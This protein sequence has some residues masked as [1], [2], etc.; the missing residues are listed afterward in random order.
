MKK[1]THPLYH[2]DT[3]VSC[4]CGNNFVTGSTQKEIRVEI[5]NNCH[6]FYT[7]K[8]NLI[9]TSGRLE[10]YEEK[11]GKINKAAAA[12]KGKKVK[13]AAMAAKKIVKNAAKKANKK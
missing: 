9:D 10:K 5:C 12:R 11:L 4:A 1:D 3:K 8:Q 2:E 7:G 6:P 13:K